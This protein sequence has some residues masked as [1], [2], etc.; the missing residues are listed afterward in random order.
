MVC[1]FMGYVFVVYALLT[2]AR[3]FSIST[4]RKGSLVFQIWRAQT[5][6]STD[7][8]SKRSTPGGNK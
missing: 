6:R 4:V 2:A 8:G 3:L 7:E 5:A 1:S